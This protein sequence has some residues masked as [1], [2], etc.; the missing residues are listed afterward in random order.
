VLLNQAGILELDCAY[1]TLD[2]FL[3]SR[4]RFY[5]HD[6]KRYPMFESGS[7]AKVFS[8]VILKNIPQQ[9]GVTSKIEGSI[10]GASRSYGEG[11]VYAAPSDKEVLG[12]NHS[13]VA[14][15]F[16]N[17]DGAALTIAI[18]PARHVEFTNGTD[19]FAVRR[20]LS[21]AYI[22]HCLEEWDATIITDIPRF[23]RLDGLDPSASLNLSFILQKWI[24]DEFAMADPIEPSLM[25]AAEARNL[26]E[27]QFFCDTFR[28]LC[29]GLEAMV[30]RCRIPSFHRA[31]AAIRWVKQCFPRDQ[32]AIGNRVSD[33]FA[34]AG[35]VLRSVSDSLRGSSAAFRGA[36]EAHGEVSSVR[37][38][39][40]T[41]T[42][43][44]D[45][46]LYRT[47]K[48]KFGGYALR[49]DTGDI[50][51][52]TE[53]TT[54]FG[55]RLFHARSSAGS[56]GT[57]GA[58]LVAGESIRRVDP[59]YIVSL[60]ICLGMDETKH[61][62]GDIVY[63]D[64]VQLYEPGKVIDPNPQAFIPR[65]SRI[66]AGPTLLDRARL[67]RRNW[68]DYN[69]RSGLIAS[70][71]KLVDSSQFIQFLK[72]IVPEAAAGEME[73][74]IVSAADRSRKEWIVIKAICD[75][76]HDKGVPS[77]SNLTF[78]S[79]MGFPK[80]ARRASLRDARRKIPLRF[81]RRYSP[82][83]GSNSRPQRAAEA[84]LAW[85]GGST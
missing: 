83:Q 48:A 37:V 43:L 75:W 69:V 68:T 18:F 54:D 49:V 23:Q 6:L 71:E 26:R 1:P 78:E 41:A 40:L 10:L 56:V 2:E 42:D 36:I 24:C 59:Q 28:A 44:E 15:A 66:P 62:I 19:A 81:I 13:K 63:S 5:G 57:S 8:Q 34:N 58:E 9:T 31:G 61:K 21:I 38:L 29:V 17:R 12:R 16:S 32:L 50:T 64:A 4:L 46:V 11:L 20:T 74:G 67:A 80:R 70:G 7:A 65:G 27:H 84:R 35:I 77:G 72:Q 51:S 3:S 39:I 79:W 53:I 33:K 25:V 30:A 73:A 82:A 52:L 76:G 55:V 45:D 60:G 14:E 85:A 47:V 22:K